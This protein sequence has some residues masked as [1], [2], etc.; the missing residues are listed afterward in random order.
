MISRD[1]VADRNT[2]GV[3]VGMGKYVVQEIKVLTHR[4]VNKEFVTQ[5][6]NALMKFGSEIR[7]EVL[8]VVAKE[9]DERC[10]I[11]GGKG[12]FCVKAKGKVD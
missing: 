4:L 7:F 10:K 3:L 1:K 12:E 11:R 9:L 5:I 8:A 6:P 2:P